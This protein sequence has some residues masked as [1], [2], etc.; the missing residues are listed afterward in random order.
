[1]NNQLQFHW[2]KINN[3]CH[4]V[5]QGDVHKMCREKAVGCLNPAEQGSGGVA[6]RSFFRFNGRW[7]KDKLHL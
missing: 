2:G 5:S 1:M 4:V 3:P 6:P 7:W